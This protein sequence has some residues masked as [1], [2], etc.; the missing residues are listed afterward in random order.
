[1]KTWDE[2]YDDVV[3]KLAERHGD[4]GDKTETEASAQLELIRQMIESPKT[5]WEF[6]KKAADDADKLLVA[7]YLRKYELTPWNVWHYGESTTG[8]KVDTK[9]WQAAAISAKYHYWADEYGSVRTTGGFVSLTA[10][11]SGFP[12]TT[13]PVLYTGWKWDD[14]V[15][16]YGPKVTAE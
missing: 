14:L 6:R 10:D 2:A 15:A 12:R 8:R 7:A 1:M 4:A 9:S 11:G 16:A 5:K 13:V 3:R